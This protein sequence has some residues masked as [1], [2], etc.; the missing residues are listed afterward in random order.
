MSVTGQISTQDLGIT[1]AHEHL[2]FDLSMWLHK[3]SPGVDRS[4]IEPVSLSNFDVI[5]RAPFSS[6]DNLT[7]TDIPT[8][9]KELNF[10]KK[11]GGSTI[12]DLTTRGL[13]PKPDSLKIRRER[14]W[15]E[16]YCRMWILH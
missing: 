15:R 2:F 6:K 3:P 16:H 1:L 8:S 12:V 13:S 14:N 10:F 4:I 5:H 11:A 7:F 9:T